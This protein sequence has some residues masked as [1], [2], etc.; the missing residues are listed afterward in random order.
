MTEYE[1]IKILKVV[2]SWLSNDNTM[3]AFRM[4]IKSLEEQSMINKIMDEV[5]QYR[6]IGTVEECQKYKKGNCI[7]RITF[8]EEKMQ[9]IVKEQVKKFEIDIDTVLNDVIDSFIEKTEERIS[10]IEDEYE[11][12]TEK[13]PYILMAKREFLNGKMLAYRSAIDTIRAGGKE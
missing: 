13:N 5:Q 12:L 10:E 11:N 4:G 6:S 9:E 7:A 8:D 2:K 1:A 3:A